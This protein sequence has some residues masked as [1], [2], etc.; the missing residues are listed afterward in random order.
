MHKTLFMKTKIANA[1]KTKYA[2]LGLSQK[3]FDGVAAILEKT[4][5][6]ENAIEATIAEAYVADLL[7]GLQGE[8]DAMRTARAQA[9][10]ALKDYKESHPET[11]P[12]PSSVPD[13]EIAKKL[14]ALEDKQ[15]EYERKISEAE[16]KARRDA[17][18]SSL[19]KLLKDKGCSN[20]FIRRTTLASVA[21]G[22]SD[23]AETLLDTY[24]GKYDENFKEA[25]GDGAIPPA[26]NRTPAEFQKGDYGS[27][28]ERLR[29]EGKLPAAK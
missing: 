18:L 1:L 10:K 3:A 16:G 2:T 6:D 13:D 23:T 9:E 4:I 29:A 21:I 14:K 26:G 20:D 12:S 27:E 5:T 17:V 25:Y 28:V 8:V 22:E 7:K 19:D 15:A 24:K 11:I